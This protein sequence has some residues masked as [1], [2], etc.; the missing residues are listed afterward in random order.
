MIKYKAKYEGEFKYV[1]KDVAIFRYQGLTSV[2]PL[3]L[4]RPIVSSTSDFS[5]IASILDL[6]SDLKEKIDKGKI[7][8]SLLYDYENYKDLII[9]G[10]EYESFVNQVIKYWIKR[11]SQRREGVVVNFD[12]ELF[13]VSFKVCNEF[14]KIPQDLIS[15]IVCTLRTIYGTEV[16]NS[17]CK[18]SC[19]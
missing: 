9:L 1:K 10:K 17:G 7:S 5:S 12:N 4:K 11:N 3:S 19:N 14:V 8:T 2:I 15:N 13:D 6:I 18:E 16:R